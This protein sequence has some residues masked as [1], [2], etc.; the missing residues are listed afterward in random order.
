MTETYEI[1]IEVDDEEI[2]ITLERPGPLT[3]VHLVTLSPPMMDDPQMAFD[4]PFLP[5][6]LEELISVVSDFPPELIDE[7]PMDAFNELVEAC[8][9]VFQGNDP[10]DGRDSEGTRI[11]DGLDLN[12]DGTVDPDDWR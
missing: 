2:P 7:L 12:D 5:L 6:F 1:S 3:S 9:L 11:F 8:S 4:D 10:T